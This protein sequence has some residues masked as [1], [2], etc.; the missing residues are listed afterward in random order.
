MKNLPIHQLISNQLRSEIQNGTYPI[1]SRLPTEEELCVRFKTSRP[2]LR[3]ALSTLS[4]E[5]LI[6]RRPRTG[7]IV[8]ASE[9]PVILSHVVNTVNELLDYPGAMTRKILDTS[10]IKAD[11]GL[12]QIIQCELDQ[13]WFRIISLRYQNQAT[14]PL[15]LT[16][17]YILPKFSGVVKHRDYL[18]KPISELIVDMYSEVIEKASVEVYSQQLSF[19]ESKV[20]STKDGSSALVVKRAYTGKDEKLFQITVSSHPEDRYRYSFELKR[21]HRLNNPSIRK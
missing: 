2:T 4:S 13:E 7:S 14:L 5:G 15:C 9:M 11:A 20:L 1:G 19:E 16:T 6:A 17:Y 12:A 21:E 10:Y 8:I 3:Q 18:I